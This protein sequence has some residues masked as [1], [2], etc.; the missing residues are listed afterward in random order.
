[1]ELQLTQTGH[2]KSVVGG[3]TDEWMERVNLL[4]ELS[5]AKAAQVTMPVQK[6]PKMLFMGHFTQI[7]VF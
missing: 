5:F 7:I 6:Y 3:W 4:L 2:P 1:M